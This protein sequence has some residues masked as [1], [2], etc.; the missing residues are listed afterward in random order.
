LRQLHGWLLIFDNAVSVEALRQW[1]PSFPVSPGSVGH[2]IVTTRRAGFSAFGLVMQLDVLARPAAVELVRSRVPSVAP[3][4]AGEIADELGYL[5]LALEQAA[6]YLDR[7]GLPPDAYLELLRTRTSDMLGRGKAGSR[8]QT[9]ATLW[10]VSFEQVREENPSA[11]QL[12]EIC[13]YLAPEG[14]PL[15]LFTKHADLLTAPLAATAAD[16]LAFGE[17]AATLLDYALVKGGPSMVH[18]HRLVQAALRGRCC[19]SCSAAEV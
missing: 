3:E 1:V 2:V 19:R 5:P 7:G 17:A 14:I 12:L 16:V 10:E 9:V 4:V 15:D 8:N 6:A 11:Y 13:A 18:M